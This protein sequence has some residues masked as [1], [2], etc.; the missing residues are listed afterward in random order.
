MTVPITILTGFLGSG[1]TTLLNHALRGPLLDRALVVVNELGDVPLDH[2]LVREVRED[3][4]LLGSGC[5]CCSIR[6]DLVDTL[7][8]ETARDRAA[9]FDRVIVE[10]TG[11]ADPTP[12]VAT[13]VRHPE[14]SRRYHL[15]AVI[16]AVDG[17]QGASTL[18]RHDE[19][20]KQ[21]IL[22]DDLV[23][24]KVDRASM[25][26]L[27]EARKAVAA[28][29]PRARVFFAEHGVLDWRPLLAWTPSTVASRLDVARGEHSHPGGAVRSFSVRSDRAV[30]FRAFALW[31]SMVSQFHGETLL[32]L[33]G[34]LRVDDEPGPR[35]VQAVQHVVYPVYSMARWPSAD[36]S[37]RLMAITRGMPPALV[38]SLRASLK[39]LIDAST[40]RSD[41][42][43]F[44]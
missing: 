6:G 44:A 15:D 13:L 9:P 35:V 16:T 19:A 32:R 4:L 34:L 17:E 18:E 23:L 7:L 36:R 29:R 28:L 38:R 5:V 20:A 39:E 43:R 22:A 37:T 41:G 33:K 24:T 42:E 14:L 11:L 25:S 3:V 26:A 30:D 40:P 21:V 10:T 8:A 31:L 27:A 12:I 2:L 1:K